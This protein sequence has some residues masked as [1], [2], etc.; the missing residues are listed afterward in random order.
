MNIDVAIKAEKGPI[1]VD[2]I[3]SSGR[4]KSVIINI[5]KGG[6]HPLLRTEVV[7]YIPS[8]TY[9][10]HAVQKHVR[11]NEI[12]GRRIH[13]RNVKDQCVSDG[14]HTTSPNV[15]SVRITA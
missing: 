15:K 12:A 7:S 3:I 9:C 13:P 1:P 11:K 14:N 4:I 6:I 8:H 2:C 10:I 5:P